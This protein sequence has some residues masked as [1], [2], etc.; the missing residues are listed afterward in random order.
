M[1]GV[2]KGISHENLEFHFLLNEVFAPHSEGVMGAHVWQGFSSEVLHTAHLAHHLTCSSSAG[3]EAGDPCCGE[4][5]VT[6]LVD[7][8]GD[9]RLSGDSE[10]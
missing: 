2:L 7:V 1:T 9:G 3:V 10:R 8:T 4:S 5:R 6:A